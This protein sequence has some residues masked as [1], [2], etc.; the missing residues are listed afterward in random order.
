LLGVIGII[1]LIGG[2]RVRRIRFCCHE[3]GLERVTLTGRQV[4]K[5]SEI[6]VFSFESRRNHS[7]G[8]YS[9]TTYTLVFADRSR[10]Q[11]RGIFFSTTVHNTD[12]EL[13]LLRDR[14]S[15]RIA[16]RMAAAYARVNRVQWTAE[17]WFHED[18]LEFS[19]PRRLFFA[20]KLTVVPYDAV[21]DFDV[22][23]GRFF[24]WTNYQERAVVSVKT[25]SANFYPGLIVLEGLVN[26]SVREPAEDWSPSASMR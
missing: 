4:L 25:S 7:H 22:R 1:C 18:V 15:E 14:V 8:R 5:F 12:E 26:A 17:M 6:D 20:P 19:C 2:V 11:G 24:L 9:G 21:T 3:H 10:E 23:D 13:E 16:R